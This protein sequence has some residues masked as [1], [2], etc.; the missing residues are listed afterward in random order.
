MSLIDINRYNFRFNQMP[1]TAPSGMY[2]IIFKNSNGVIS[3]NIIGNISGIIQANLAI[4]D[5]SNVV[6]TKNVMSGLIA[7]L[8]GNAYL[9]EY[10]NSLN[11]LPNTPNI[12]I[13]CNSFFNFPPLI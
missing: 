7:K 2:N 3:N 8:Q 9:S 12:S 1:D 10:N 4:I 5:N 13:T 6:C 11:Q